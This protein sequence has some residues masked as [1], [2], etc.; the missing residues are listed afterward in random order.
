MLLEPIPLRR[1]Q[2]LAIIVTTMLFSSSHPARM[3]QHSADDCRYSADRTADVSAS[4]ITDFHLDAG[5]GSLRVVGRRGITTIQVHAHACASSRDIL[6]G[7]Q[8]GARRS[9]N[10]YSVSSLPRDSHFMDDEYGRMDLVIEVPAAIDAVIEDG[11]G[12]ASISGLHSLDVSDGS[13]DL[14]IT[15]IGGDVTVDDGSGDL[16]SAGVRGDVDVDD[17]SGEVHVRD[18]GGSVTMSDGSGSLFVSQVRGNFTVTE[19]GSGDIEQSD[20]SGAVRIPQ[21]YRRHR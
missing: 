5:A 11:S 16:T 19:D 21:K 10:T 1:L 8:L 18:V 6:N 9:G 7:L 17:G 15:D 14:E 3:P 2:M 12:D 4:G 13:G 20:I